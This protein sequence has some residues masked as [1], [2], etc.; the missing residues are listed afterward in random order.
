MSCN[1]RA[2][3]CP[4]NLGECPVK[5]NEILAKAASVVDGREA[6]YGVPSENLLNIGILWSAYIEAKYCG[7]IISADTST[8]SMVYLTAED[9]AWLNV[10]Q[11]CARSMQGLMKPDNYIDAAGY[12]ALAGEVAA[13]DAKE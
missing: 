1:G 9:V 10:L 2:L 13:E 5:K 7:K 6:E 12:S 4:P 3:V 11:K 8:E